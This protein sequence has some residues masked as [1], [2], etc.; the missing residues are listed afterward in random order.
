M[1]CKP[2]AKV[3]DKVRLD[4]GGK[5]KM[6]LKKIYHPWSMGTCNECTF[7]KW[8]ISN[9]GNKWGGQVTIGVNELDSSCEQTKHAQAKPLPFQ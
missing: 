1:G 8:L 7:F 6:N 5:F 9:W 2:R 4:D 3:D